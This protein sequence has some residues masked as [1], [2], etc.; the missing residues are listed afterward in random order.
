M[1]PISKALFDA[2]YAS[3]DNFTTGCEAELY[4]AVAREARQA[5]RLRDGRSPRQ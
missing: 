2:G 3:E 4:V 5:G 1:G